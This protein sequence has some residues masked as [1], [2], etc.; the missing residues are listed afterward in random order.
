MDSRTQAT[1]K[2]FAWDCYQT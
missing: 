2:D 1:R